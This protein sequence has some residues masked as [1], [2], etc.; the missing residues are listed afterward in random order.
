M[1][2]MLMAGLAVAGCSDAAKTIADAIASGGDTAAGAD[3]SLPDT[4][5]DPDDA[6]P[7]SACVDDLIPPMEWFDDRLTQTVSGSIEFGQTHVSR[8]DDDRWAPPLIEHRAALLLFSPDEALNDASDGRLAA[9]R[10]SELI[11]VMRLA[12]PA[13]LPTPL[14]QDLTEVALEPWS[15]TAW[16]AALPWQWVEEG[17]R[18]TIGIDAGDAVLTAEHTLTDLGAPQ[19]FTLSRSKM[20]LFGE[21]DHPTTTETAERI[22]RDFFAAVPV[23]SMRWVDSAPWRLDEIVVRADGGPVVVASE[24]ERLSQT[25]DPDRWHI[26]KHQFAIAM[27]LANTGRGLAKTTGGDSSP[28]AFG[29][30]VGSGWVRNDDGTYSDLDN[31]PYAAGWTGW[32]A[33]W[34]GECANV[35][36]HEI[37]HSFTLA[38]FTAGTGSAWGIG[39]EYPLDGVNLEAHPWGFDST[40]QRFRTWYRVNA[41]GPVVAE[42]GGWQGKRDPMNGGE[43]PNS[44]SCFPQYTPYH[45]WK[46]QDWSETRPTI[47]RIDGEPGVYTWDAESRTM[48]KTEPV[49]DGS[50]APVAVDVPVVT[51]IGTIAHRPESSR[52]YPPIHWASGNSFDFA[53]P[54]DATLHPHYAG[55][56]Y[57]VEIE[58]AD[59]SSEQRL[60]AQP[61]VPATDTD[62]YLWSVNLESGRSPERVSLFQTVDPHPGMDVATA[63]LLHSARIDPPDEPVPA[64]VLIGNGFVANGAVSLTE[65]C[66][67]DI[68]CAQ[69]A[70]STEW[71]T[72]ATPLRFTERADAPDPAIACSEDGSV[73][74]LVV[75]IQDQ[76]GERASLVVHAQRTVQTA[77]HQWAGPINDDTPWIDADNV[78]QGLR[79]WV[80]HAPNADLPVGTWSN[81]DPYTLTALSEGS[82]FATVPLVINLTILPTDAVDVGGGYEGPSVTTEGSSTFFTVDDP[83]MGPTEGVWW[84]SSAATPLTIPVRNTATGA[85][86]QLRLDGWKRSCDLGWGTWWSLNSAQVADGSCEQRPQLAVSSSGNEHLESGETYASPPSGPLILRAHAWHLGKRIVDT[87]AIEVTYTVP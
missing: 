34:L 28:Y 51:V 12:P 76:S 6:D 43:S 65:W 47:A 56:N 57:F 40:R 54:G 72:G 33:M 48:V 39:D 18:L 70:R 59:G 31:A 78:R 21:A 24:G 86:T 64:P 4:A 44:A 87:R 71:A 53:A 37:G 27:S 5:V 15:T 35:F 82:A 73:T 26:L 81:A 1:R 14:E 32:T 67:P 49:E 20:V 63:S 41:D 77:T 11:G 36:I 84:G 83:A 69:R 25:S 42:S 23:S 17:T 68:N 3:A 80:P 52:V 22:G 30:S 45:A 2:A 29:T 79:A 60:I 62:L 13:Q 19:R 74:E 85:T 61:T 8:P 50:M 10:G 55:S 7:Y 9:W 66:E 58:Y 75:P 46:I 38:H 16:S